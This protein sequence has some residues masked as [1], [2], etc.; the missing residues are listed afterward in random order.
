MDEDQKLNI[1][2]IIGVIMIIVGFYIWMTY[3]GSQ[4][5]LNPIYIVGAIMALFGGYLALFYGRTRTRDIE[6]K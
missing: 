1:I 2:K 6:E 4:G 3:G 5:L